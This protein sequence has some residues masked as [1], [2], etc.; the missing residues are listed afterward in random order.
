MSLSHFWA[1]ASPSAFDDS[2]GV[3]D[4]V[5]TADMS[6]QLAPCTSLTT[7]AIT[8]VDF[9]IVYSIS[10]IN[11]EVRLPVTGWV[12][13]LLVAL[14][15]GSTPVVAYSPTQA[16]P[17]PKSW[18]TGGSSML[19]LVVVACALNI[20]SRSRLHTTA[21]VAVLLAVGAIVSFTPGLC[22]VFGLG[23]Q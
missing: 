16:T 6:T 11:R 12:V 4:D 3:A 13:M 9:T 17:T 21:F 1:L 2:T 10:I 7:I 14:C 8:V 15:A 18:T 19:S 5:H 22:S 23:Q 20:G